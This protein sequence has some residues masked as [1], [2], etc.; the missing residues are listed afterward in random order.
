MFSRSTMMRNT[1]VGIETG[2]YN[3]QNNIFLGFHAYS[4]RPFQKD[5]LR[6]RLTHQPTKRVLE[7]NILI[8]CTKCV[9]FESRRENTKI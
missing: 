4:H 3:R 5:G 2:G 6:F 1:I 9:S 8:A 7:Q